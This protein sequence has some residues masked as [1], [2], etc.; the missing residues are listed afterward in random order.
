MNVIKQVQPSRVPRVGG[1][2]PIPDH[3]LQKLEPLPPLYTQEELDELRQRHMADPDDEEIMWFLETPE[4]LQRV[5][6][7]REAM[8]KRGE[9]AMRLDPE[10]KRQVEEYRRMV[11]QMLKEASEHGM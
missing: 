8:D 6:R 4:Q 5:Q 10:Y 1:Y 11:E 9:Q 7:R 2:L 3:L